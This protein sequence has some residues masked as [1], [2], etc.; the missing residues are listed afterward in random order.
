MEGDRRDRGVGDESRC[1]TLIF[2][3]SLENRTTCWTTVTRTTCSPTYHS[4]LVF[5]SGETVRTLTRYMGVPNPI[6]IKIK[7]K[8]R[9][10]RGGGDE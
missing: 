10:G 7:A 8:N 4:S 1:V 9:G 3:A 5:V 6:A 2:A